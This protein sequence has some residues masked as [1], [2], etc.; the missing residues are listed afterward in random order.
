MTVKFQTDEDR[1]LIEL[2]VPKTEAEMDEMDQLISAIPLGDVESSD[3]DSDLMIALRDLRFGLEA[4]Q[5]GVTPNMARLRW[6]IGESLH[7]MQNLITYD[8]NVTKNNLYHRYGAALR[9]SG[10]DEGRHAEM[11]EEFRRLVKRV[12][13]ALDSA[14]RELETRWGSSSEDGAR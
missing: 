13:S 1:E 14:D 5:Y 11:R 8:G 3:D 10:Y 12:E 6:M 9:A 7:E 4:V 2:P